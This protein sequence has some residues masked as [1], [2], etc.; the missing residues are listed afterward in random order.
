M[1]VTTSAC[2]GSEE[3]PEETGRPVSPPAVELAPEGVPEDVS[4]GV[5]VSLTSAPGEGAQWNEAAEGARVAAYRYGLGDVDVSLV[6][7]DDQGTADGADAAVRELAEEGVSG[8][9]MATEGKHVTG[10][11]DAA[12]ELG[13][14]VLLP[15]ADTLVRPA[16]G[17]LD[18]RRRRRVRCRPP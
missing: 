10:A 13:V 3:S 17:R 4:I 8:I 5:V 6:P 15:Y 9:V 1:L 2:T 18:D 11:L 12:S 16:R 7:R 14:P